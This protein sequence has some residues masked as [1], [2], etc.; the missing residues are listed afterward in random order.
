MDLKLSN[1]YVTKEQISCVFVLFFPNESLCD[2]LKLMLEN[3]YTVIAVING[4]AKELLLKLKSIDKL[5]NII[6]T[7]NM[8]V[9]TALNQG[10]KLALENKSINYINLFDQDSLP[11][12]DL[13]L[14]LANELKQMGES[15]YASIGPKLIE[16][17]SPNLKYNQYYSRRKKSFLTIPTSGKLITRSSYFSVGP[18]LDALFIDGV[19][20]EWCFRA[21][22]K[23][24]KIGKSNNI[25]MIH[26]MGDSGFNYFGKYKPIHQ[27]P[28]R[29]YYITRNTIF[30][31]KAEF[32]PFA[33][34][35]KQLFKMLRRI[36][37]YILIS[38]NRKITI[39]LILKAIID[40]CNNR[41]GRL[42]LNSN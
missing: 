13:P 16:I 38:E 40:G 28:I 23:G 18:M 9:A 37:F 14:K 19:D 26:N 3:N 15:K 2:T 5:K 34:R 36:L 27:S 7:E 10:I 20:D 12:F 31:S 42:E 41:L 35:F 29:H 21:L 17:K 8:G 33:W 32:I 1:E 39:K 22:Y 4:V 30:L 24:F 25:E 11:D 6:N